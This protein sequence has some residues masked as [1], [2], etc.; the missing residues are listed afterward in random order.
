M[1]WSLPHLP[2]PDSFFSAGTETYYFKLLFHLKSEK[3][4]VER[5]TGWWDQIV[6]SVNFILLPNRKTCRKCEDSFEIKIKR[7]KNMFSVNMT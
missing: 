5:I 1:S 4:L 3:L 2:P 6:L 7:Q